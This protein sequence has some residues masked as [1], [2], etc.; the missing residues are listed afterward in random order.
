MI[1]LASYLQLQAI[2]EL[3]FK[4]AFGS[5][6]HVFKFK[7]I[8]RIH[9]ARRVRLFEFCL[10]ILVYCSQWL[11]VANYFYSFFLEIISYVLQS[12]KPKEWYQK[13]TV[14][15]WCV[16]KMNCFI[17]N[18]M[19]YHNIK[20][21]DDRCSDEGYNMIG[22]NVGPFA[23]I[24]SYLWNDNHTSS[25]ANSRCVTSKLNSDWPE[26][27]AMV[28]FC[29]QKCSEIWKHQDLWLLKCSGLSLQRGRT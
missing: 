10:E 13:S 3:W 12:M 19:W 7:C 4:V 29:K 27:N 20:D 25:R 14:N 21:F 8:N 1:L 15:T 23:E 5:Y 26:Y 17:G 9:K 6:S 11:Y 16:P 28:N 18:V 2:K 22:G 24:M